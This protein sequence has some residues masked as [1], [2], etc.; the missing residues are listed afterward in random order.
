MVNIN[1]RSQ[2]KV[3][4]HL[5]QISHWNLLKDSAFWHEDKSNQQLFRLNTIERILIFDQT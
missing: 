4:D 1:T 2:K 5:R 3:I